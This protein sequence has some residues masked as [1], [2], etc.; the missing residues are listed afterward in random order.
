MIMLHENG[1][2]LKETLS[3]SSAFF[4]LFLRLG[5]PPRYLIFHR[6]M[7][8]IIVSKRLLRPLRK[9]VYIYI[10]FLSLIQISC[11][12]FFRCQKR[13]KI[14]ESEK[15]LRLGVEK[16]RERMGNREKT[17]LPPLSSYLAPTRVIKL[18]TAPS[19]SRKTYKSKPLFPLGENI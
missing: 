10:F 18:R 8:I 9:G 13:E 15:I 14:R 12:F 19:L 7:M 2:S 16:E 1:R 6:T 17:Q 4:L 11:V 5:G 3:F